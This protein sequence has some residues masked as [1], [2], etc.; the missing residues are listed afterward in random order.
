ML[1]ITTPAADFTLL[2][3]AEMREAAGVTD[4]TQDA[5]LQLMEAR[6]ADSI[7]SYC[8]IAI[9]GE[10]RP[11]LRRETVTE[12]FRL[13]DQP[14]LILSRRH[15][16]NPTSVEVDGVALDADEYEAK[17]ESGLLY[18]LDEDTPIPWCG[19][20][21]IVVYQAGFTTVPPDLKMAAVDFFRFAWKERDRDP[22]IKSREVDIPGVERD[23]TEWW[24]GA[25]PGMAESAVPEIVSGQLVRFRNI[26]L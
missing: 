8:N 3:I 21:I 13:V 7:C 17:P 4:G 25:A 20:K 11:T 12:T 18:R 5:A 19:R 22:S 1:T 10:S 15:G 26:A 24:I 2:T 14:T 23:K 16:V 9:A 6:I